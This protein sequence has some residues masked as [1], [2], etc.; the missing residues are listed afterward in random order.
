MASNVINTV[1]SAPASLKQQARG[2]HHL[3]AEAPEERLMCGIAGVFGPSHGSSPLESMVSC[4]RH[5][6]PDSAGI[7]T[8]PSGLASLGHRRLSIIDLSDAGRQPMASHDSTL[9][10]HV[11]W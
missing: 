5:R 8:S 6:G 7:W 3:V 11:Q 10:N 4:Q 2:T 1:Q 9:S